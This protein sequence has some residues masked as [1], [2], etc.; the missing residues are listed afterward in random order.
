MFT[1]A[2]DGGLTLLRVDALCGAFLAPF[3][4]V[5][6]AAGRGVLVPRVCTIW[7]E[8]TM[9]GTDEVAG[10]REPL[11]RGCPAVLGD[12]LAHALPH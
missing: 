1:R 9:G 8:T 10:V 6:G 2:N 5:D 11:R 7:G 3:D 4:V 12:F